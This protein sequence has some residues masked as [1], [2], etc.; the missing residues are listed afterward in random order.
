MLNTIN[1]YIYLS[2]YIKMFH[3]LN[4]MFMNNIKMIDYRIKYQISY[5]N[6]V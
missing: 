4:L 2:N 6:V 1:L 5:F 3:L